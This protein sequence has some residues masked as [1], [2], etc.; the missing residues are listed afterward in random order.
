VKKLSMRGARLSSG[1]GCKG[2]DGA[3][4]SVIWQGSLQG[5]EMTRIILV[6]RG[7]TKWNVVERFRGRADIPLDGTGLTQAEALGLR[8]SQTFKPEAIYTSPIMRA[9]QTAE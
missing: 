9:R 7:Q 1:N 6:R 8:I 5:L 4:Y 2:R 3:K